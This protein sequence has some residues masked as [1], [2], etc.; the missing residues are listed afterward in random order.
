MNI[1]NDIVMRAQEK[2]GSMVTG[3]IK[4]A[5]P[6]WARE[7]GNRAANPSVKPEKIQKMQE[8][9]Q[10]IADILPKGVTRQVQDKSIGR[11]HESAVF[12]GFTGGGVGDSVIKVP[13]DEPGSGT[14]TGGSSGVKYRLGDD[15]FA[16]M[17]GA[18]KRLSPQEQMDIMN[19]NKGLFAEV[20]GLNRRGGYSQQLME[21]VPA[22]A[23]L[24]VKPGHRYDNLRNTVSML[25]KL[26]SA[27][28]ASKY[29]MG[30]GA[31]SQFIGDANSGAEGVFKAIMKDRHKLFPK[32]VPE[33]MR[34]EVTR[35]F[36][37][38]YSNL[39]AAQNNKNLLDI[40]LP[41]GGFKDSLRLRGVDL[42]GARMMDVIPSM[43]HNVMKDPRTGQYKITD[44][45]FTKVPG[46]NKA[47]TRQRNEGLMAR[48][49]RLLV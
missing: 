23:A 41:D 35:G 15:L 48:L 42:G 21:E 14:I 36:N 2:L 13:F 19:A 17:M 6:R 37:G 20:Y 9:K 40:L 43:G 39:Y 1:I 45:I 47:D 18:P 3:H 38:L 30:E 12:K 25:R 49:Q 4:E 7:L 24:G 32:P 34:D 8:L 46:F 22:L 33:S 29:Y 27:R 44:P 16:R 26:R 28:D 31:L 10:Q 11:G 5:K